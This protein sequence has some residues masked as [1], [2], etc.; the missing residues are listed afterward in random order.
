[1]LKLTPSCFSPFLSHKPFETVHVIVISTVT[2]LT[3]FV[4]CVLSISLQRKKLKLR[5]VEG[6]AHSH[7]ILACV[8]A[9]DF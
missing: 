8:L 5:E 7:A 6:L 3:Y 1:M 2:L 4:S 9:Q